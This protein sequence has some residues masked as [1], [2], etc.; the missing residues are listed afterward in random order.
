HGSVADPLHPPLAALGLVV[1]DDGVALEPNMALAQG[2]EPVAL[3][4]IRV[5][6]AAGAEEAQVEESRRRC[7]HAGAAHLTAAEVAR[8][9]RAHAGQC[10]GEVEHRV[11]L[12]LIAAR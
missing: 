7:Q 2:G 3:V 6:L 10:R 8:A 11:E 4:L 9:P 5:L 12:L 1:E